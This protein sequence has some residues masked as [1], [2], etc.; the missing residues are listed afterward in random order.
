MTARALHLVVDRNS[1]ALPSPDA[2]ALARVAAGDVAALGEVFDRHHRSL[3]R[4][5]TRLVGP[6]DAE[7]IVQTTFVRAAKAAASFDPSAASARP[8]LTGIASRVVLEGRR[9]FARFGRVLHALGFSD[10]SHAPEGG[11]RT[12][13]QRALARLS[14]AKRVVLLLAEVEEYTC[15]EIAV[16]LDLPVGTVWT[17]LHH[18]RKEL[19]AHFEGER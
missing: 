2:L 9:T 5:A 1:P 16:L 11:A 13:I 3:V 4:F 8:W 7:D 18:A 15:E 14:D 10:Q 6:R 12:D 19:R 17:R